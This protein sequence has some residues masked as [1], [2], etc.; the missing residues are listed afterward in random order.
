MV[1]GLGSVTPTHIPKRKPVEEYLKLRGRFRHLF[2]P[3]RQD[4]AIRHIQE[5]V[6]AY[7]QEAKKTGTASCR[8]KR[9]I[10]SREV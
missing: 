8:A 4:E 2:E 10:S 7:R 9:W 1:G 5:R 3:N 6:D